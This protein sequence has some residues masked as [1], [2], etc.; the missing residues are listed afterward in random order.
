MKNG[1]N[2]Q[3]N[4]NNSMVTNDRNKGIENSIS[5]SNRINNSVT[6]RSGFPVRQETLIPLNQRTK[7]TARVFPTTLFTTIGSS[8]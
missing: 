7:T 1:R 5:E 4:L 8:P 3:N 6:A 2:N